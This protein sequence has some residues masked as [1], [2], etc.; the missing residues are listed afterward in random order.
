[1]KINRQLQFYRSSLL[2]P[3]TATPPDRHE[4]YLRLWYTTNLPSFQLSQQ[5]IWRRMS[6]HYILAS[7]T[8]MTVEKTLVI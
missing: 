1:M 6:L 8:K 3:A 7:A 4:T 2:I 5:V